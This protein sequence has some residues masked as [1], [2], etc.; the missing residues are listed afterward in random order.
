MSEVDIDELCEYR[1]NKDRNESYGNETFEKI[2]LCFRTL[3]K[4]EAGAEQEHSDHRVSC[5]YEDVQ[6]LS[7]ETGVKP[8]SACNLGH[9]MEA[10][11]D[12]AEPKKTLGL[13][14]RHVAFVPFFFLAEFNSDKQKRSQRDI[15]DSDHNYPRV[16]MRYSNQV[17]ISKVMLS[18]LGIR[19]H[20]RIFR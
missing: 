8:R 2:R 5:C 18:V 19:T 6:S 12:G 13:V 7:D 10:D 11:D 17:I 1:R 15:P 16:N 4:T 3:V 14:K 9:V 20:C